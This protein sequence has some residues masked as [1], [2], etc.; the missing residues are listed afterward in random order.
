MESFHL[1]TM[2]LICLLPTLLLFLHRNRFYRPTATNGL[3]L[4]PLLLVI[5]YSGRDPHFILST[6]CFLLFLTGPLYLQKKTTVNILNNK[7]PAARRCLNLLKF[8]SPLFSS[9]E[10]LANLAL[11]QR[12]FKE[13][14]DHSSL[15]ALKASSVPSVTTCVQIHLLSVNWPVSEK[16]LANFTQKEIRSMPWLSL[17]Q[18]RL[19]CEKGDIGFAREFIEEINQ[20][21]EQRSYY[22]FHLIYLCSF[23]GDQESLQRLFERDPSIPERSQH[24]WRT[25]CLYNNSETRDNAKL[26]L[27][28][29]AQSDDTRLARSSAHILQQCRPFPTKSDD[30]QEMVHKLEVNYEDY[31]LPT[32]QKY[33]ITSFL[34][35][36]NLLIFTLTS[37][38]TTNTSPY[39]AVTNILGMKLP[40]MVE[41]SEYWRLLTT[42]FLHSGLLHLFSNMTIILFF[43]VLLERCFSA[44]KLLNIYLISGVLGMIVVTI[45]SLLYKEPP[46]IT[47]GASGSA[48]ALLGAYL[49]V[50]LRQN[51]RATLKIRQR[52]ILLLFCFLG[53]QSYIDIKTPQISFTAHFVGLVS[54][55]LMAYFLYTEKHGKSKLE[56]I[57]KTTK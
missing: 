36:V 45:I 42:T 37:S 47:V 29:L 27:E 49:A 19:F 10:C 14:P 48:M 43:G 22:I 31:C 41:T 35:G 50:L 24:F 39:D 17:L 7:Y 6:S 55:L 40:E 34:I 11:L 2:V 20:R 38:L 18:I 32:P 23:S 53:M 5:H 1:W 9:R 16:W 46:S 33:P 13:I 4:M 15:L 44:L 21:Q 3:L 28:H 56:S 8:I 54:G 52:Q 57:P 51:K 12:S 26:S 30:L 25:V